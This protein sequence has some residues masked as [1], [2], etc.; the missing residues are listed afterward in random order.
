MGRE[1]L[2]AASPAVEIT[3]AV[4]V[5]V[6]SRA[7]PGRERRERRRRPERQ[8]QRRR[9]GAADGARGGLGLQRRGRRRGPV[10]AHPVHELDALGLELEQRGAAVGAGVGDPLGLGHERPRGVAAPALSSAR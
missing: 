1:T 10:A 4:V 8:R 2:S 7:T 9:H 6:Y 3:V 5:A